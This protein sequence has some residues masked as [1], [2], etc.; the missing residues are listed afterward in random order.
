MR[1][2][3]REATGTVAYHARKAA[4]WEAL[5]AR[6]AETA[7]DRLEEQEQRHRQE[8]AERDAVI[9]RLIR[10]RD[11]ALAELTRK[12]GPSAGT[13]YRAYKKLG[14]DLSEKEK[15]LELATRLDMDARTVRRR[16][17]EFIDELARAL[18]SD[19]RTVRR[20]LQHTRA[21]FPKK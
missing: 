2:P 1:R 5:A 14:A 21:A 8:L 7:L 6:N 15:E 10:E 17:Q 19:A 3:P 16:L 4:E 9:E 13:V 18:D 12:R 11:E 20:Q